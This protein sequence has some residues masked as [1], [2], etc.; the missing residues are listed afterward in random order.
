MDKESTEPRSYD[1]MEYVRAKVR[2]IKYHSNFGTSK[3]LASRNY[4]TTN[5]RRAKHKAERQN[6]KKGRA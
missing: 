4:L 1:L 6:K 2:A 5:E 3:H